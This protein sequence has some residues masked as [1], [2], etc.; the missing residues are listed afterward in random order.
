MVIKQIYI[1]QSKKIINKY[2]K[3]LN[4]L[5]E[6]EDNLVDNKKFI[7]NLQKEISNIDGL[8]SNQLVKQQKLE[9]LMIEYDIKINK[10]EQEIK[11]ILEELE[12]LKKQSKI[13]YD[14]IMIDYSGYSETEIQEQIKKQL[15]M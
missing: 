3:I 1:D 5:K 2:N 4:L 7:L 12:N 6:Q 8:S 9:E 10:L 13:L 11:P 14:K 15:Q